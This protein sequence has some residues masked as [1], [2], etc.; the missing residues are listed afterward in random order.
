MFYILLFDCYASVVHFHLKHNRIKPVNIGFKVNV[1][2]E[3]GL[4]PEA[5]VVIN[6]ALPKIA[7]D[8]FK[9]NN[10]SSSINLV[11]DNSL[12]E[13]LSAGYN[14]G[15]SWDGTTPEATYFYT[16]P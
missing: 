14:L 8:D 10:L 16:L 6:L 7:S 2:G 3:K 13:K 9:A 12:S 15:F 5:G 1:C 4:R 11:F